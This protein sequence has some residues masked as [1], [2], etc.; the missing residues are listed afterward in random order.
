MKIQILKEEK[1][2]DQCQ[3]NEIHEFGKWNFISSCIICG[4]DYCS[5]C[6]KKGIMTE[7]HIS[8][9]AGNTNYVCKTCLTSTKLTQNQNLII[10]YLKQQEE[11]RKNDELECTNRRIRNL[12]LDQKLYNLDPKTFSICEHKERGE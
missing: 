8:S 6:I 7:F 2:C 12:E 11:N 10:I 5:N 3:T 4:K 1:Q 9:F